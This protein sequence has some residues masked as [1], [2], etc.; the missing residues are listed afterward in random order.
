MCGNSASAMAL[1]DDDHVAGV[2]QIE[3][4]NEAAL[5]HREQRHGVG[6]VRFHAA[7]DHALHVLAP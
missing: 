3:L 1:A 2:L 6:I 4:R 7:H 5:G